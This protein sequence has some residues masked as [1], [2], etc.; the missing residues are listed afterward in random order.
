MKLSQKQTLYDYLLEKTQG[1]LSKHTVTYQLKKIKPGVRI[2]CSGKEIVGVGLDSVKPEELDCGQILLAGD[3]MHFSGQ[4]IHLE[5]LNPDDGEVVYFSNF[6][7]QGKEYY[8][9]TEDG[10]YLEL[11]HISTKDLTINPVQNLTQRRIAKVQLYFETHKERLK[12]NLSNQQIYEAIGEPTK[13][14][15]WKEFHRLYPSVFPKNYQKNF[16]DD[17]DFPN[18]S[19]KAGNNPN[20]NSIALEHQL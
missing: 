11:A 13:A 3:P 6:R 16:F 8:C 12:A 18:I 4:T 20:R 15:L 1:N 7:F 2:S 5:H 17:P 14:A 10:M 9:S 19:F